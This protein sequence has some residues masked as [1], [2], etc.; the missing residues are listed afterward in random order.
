M[1]FPPK[2]RN[3]RCH[4]HPQDGLKKRKEHNL[5]SWVLFIDFVKTFDRV[6]REKLWIFFKVRHPAKIHSTHHCPE[7]HHRT[8]F[9]WWRRSRDWINNWSKT[10]WRFRPNSFYYIHGWYH[11]H[12]E[13]KR[14]YLTLPL[15]IKTRLHHHRMTSQHHTWCGGIRND[16]IRI[17]RRCCLY[18]PIQRNFRTRHFPNHETL[19]RMG[20]GSSLWDHRNPRHKRQNI[21]TELLFVAEPNNSYTEPPTSDDTNISPIILEEGHFIPVINKFCYLGSIINHNLRESED[22]DNRTKKASQAFGALRRGVFTSKSTSFN[23]KKAV[24]TD[25]ILSVLIHGAEACSLPEI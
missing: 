1:W 16:R 3:G 11:K 9:N 4:L 24:Y 2:T 5:E 20:N 7:L 17:C 12:M 21:K 8:T 6:H 18:L 13:T 10:R 25:L 14:G 23:V 19:R 15:Q 22:V